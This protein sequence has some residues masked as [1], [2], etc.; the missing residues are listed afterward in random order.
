VDANVA[1]EA[2][3]SADKSHQ[4][5]WG[6]VLTTTPIVLTVLAT[7]FAGLSSSEM[8]QSMYYR[9]LAAQHQS[10][11]GDQWGFFQAKRIRG[12]SLE[13]TS[14]LLQSLARPAEFDLALLETGTAQILQHLEKAKDNNA[15]AEPRRQAAATAA[16]KVKDIRGQL[17]DLRGNNN[18]LYLDKKK[19]LP[20]VELSQL[21]KKEAREELAAV[22]KAVSERQPEQ[23][24]T[25]L[26]AK[27]NP[28]DIEKAARLVEEDA[29]RF[30]KE[31]NAIDDTLKQLRN[32]LGKL[33]VV[34][35]PLR[36]LN[37]D[38]PEDPAA[39]A[40]VPALFDRLNTGFQVALLDFD[41]RRYRREAE[42]NRQVAEVYEVRVRWSS[43]ASDRHR[44]RSKKFFYSMLLAQAGVTISSLALAG[45]KRSWL[46]FLAA[47]AGL[48][49]IGFTGYV[50]FLL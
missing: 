43:L 9:S 3:A 49:A 33:D 15:E 50:Y 22:V 28:V 38:Q 39:L 25:S 41:R 2:E 4:G 10:K 35:Q 19:D 26:V 46:W 6:T 21:E 29:E 24:T 12:T 1:K 48:S 14:Q 17:T 7:V 44:E 20:V 34:L 45:A 36:D 16:A 30:D 31:C 13:M 11:A 47:L 23:A 40:Q 42:Y 5:L 37:L 27:L 18:L 32:L 8:T